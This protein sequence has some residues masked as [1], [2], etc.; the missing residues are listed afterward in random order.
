MD[1]ALLIPVINLLYK[2][3]YSDID[4]LKYKFDSISE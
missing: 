1:F 4:L 3:I 2:D